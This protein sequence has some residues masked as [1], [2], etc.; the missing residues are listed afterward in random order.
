[1]SK[2]TPSR[3]ICSNCQHEAEYMVWQSLNV[4]VDP[5]D[6]ELLFNADINVFECEACSETF[7]MDTWFAY[8]DMDKKF[9]VQYIP[10][11]ELE[12][13]DS[14]NDYGPDGSYTALPEIMP[15][16]MDYMEHPHIVFS[17]DELVK[18]VI[19]RDLV[20]DLHNQL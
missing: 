13:P 19:F 8:H 16:G 17:M 12:N 1:M 4:T 11:Y 6:K 10:K 5:D 18:H 7:F 3:I 2:K 20:F 15:P 14:F 9:Y